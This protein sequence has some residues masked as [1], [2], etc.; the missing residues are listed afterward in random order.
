[1]NLLEE[2]ASIK[3]ENGDPLLIDRN[4]PALYSFEGGGDEGDMMVFICLVKKPAGSLSDEQF[5]RVFGAM[6][7]VL[8]E[9]RGEEGESK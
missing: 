7:F 6:N 8:G 5:N 4:K 1:M 9:G 2:L 3:D